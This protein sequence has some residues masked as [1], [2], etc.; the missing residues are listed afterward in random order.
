MQEESL[1]LYV[2]LPLDAVSESHSINHARAIAAGLKALKLLG[3]DGVEL[4][5]WWGIVEK[6][7]MGK[8]NW[9]GYLALAQLVQKMGLKL[10]V[11]ICFHGCNQC[12]I[13]LPGWVSQIGE[14]EPNIFFSDRSGQQYKDCLSLSVDDLPVLNGKTPLQVYK[15]FCEN[16]KTSFSP[17]LG[18]TITVSFKTLFGIYC[19]TVCSNGVIC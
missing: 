14:S 9:T 2:G 10:H 12:K 13:P 8:Y 18:S 4:P 7:G 17:F 5:I 3:V 11:S 16:F 1:K 19:I 15:D 6:E